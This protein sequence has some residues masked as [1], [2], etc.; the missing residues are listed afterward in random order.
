MARQYNRERIYT[1][2][3]SSGYNKAKQSESSRRVRFQRESG[4]WG[5]TI[6]AEKQTP[7]MEKTHSSGKSYFADSVDTQALLDQ[8]A[9]QGTLVLDRHGKFTNKE[10]VKDVPLPGSVIDTDGN[11]HAITGFTIHHSKQRT[12]IV[13]YAEKGDSK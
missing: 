11:E 4:A 13:P 3:D 2:A 5:T 7:H 10:V 6:N 12:H 1:K 8:Y 9:G